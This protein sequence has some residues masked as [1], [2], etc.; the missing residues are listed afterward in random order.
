MSKD[1]NLKIGITFSDQQ[2]VTLFTDNHACLGDWF[3]DSS[4]KQPFRGMKWDENTYAY[5][6]YVLLHKGTI[7]IATSLD[8]LYIDECNCEWSELNLDKLKKGMKIYL[9]TLLI[10]C[11]E[12]PYQNI[13]PSEYIQTCLF[14]EVRYY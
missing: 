5:Y 7:L 1:L 2:L 4:V 9:K 12:T 3:V 14:G 8:I 10:D 13:D 6:D 11:D